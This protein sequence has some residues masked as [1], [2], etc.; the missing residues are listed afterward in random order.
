MQKK[1]VLIEKQII[2]YERLRWIDDIEDDL[3][4]KKIRAWR[5]KTSDRTEWTNVVKQAKILHGL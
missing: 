5:K 4:G 2:D 3:R 1:I